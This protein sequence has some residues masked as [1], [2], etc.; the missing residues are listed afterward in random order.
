MAHAGL[1]REQVGQQAFVPRAVPEVAGH[2]VGERVRMH[3]SHPQQALQAVPALRE[4]RQPV[5]IERGA[6]LLQHQ[7]QAFVQG[8]VH[9]L[10]P[11]RRSERAQAYAECASVPRR[12]DP[13]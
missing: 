7:V 6:L 13:V 2:R 9:G 5:A 3:G 1:D 10:S 12:K 8:L 4:R 11:P